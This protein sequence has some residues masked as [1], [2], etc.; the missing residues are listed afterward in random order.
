MFK[1]I[2]A[3]A[4]ILPLM[5]SSFSQAGVISYGQTLE[6]LC[7]D[8]TVSA[9]DYSIRNQ[10]EIPAYANPNNIQPAKEI[11]LFVP[12]EFKNAEMIVLN[13]AVNRVSKSTF[14]E[15]LLTKILRRDNGEDSSIVNVKLFFE[16][17]IEFGRANFNK[18][19][20]VTE[21]DSIHELYGA[22]D[23][24]GENGTI[25]LNNYQYNVNLPYTFIHELFHLLDGNEKIGDHIIDNFL[26]E[27]R[28]LLAEIKFHQEHIKYHEEKK[29]YYMAS[30]W[31]DQFFGY[32]TNT[33]KEAFKKTLD[34]L[35]PE[36]PQMSAID[37]NSFQFLVERLGYGNT[38]SPSIR[39]GFT[40]DPQILKSLAKTN[41]EKRDY[42]ENFFDKSENREHLNPSYLNNIRP[43]GLNNFESIGGPRP[44]GATGG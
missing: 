10:K 21:R 41:K 35:Y 22:F 6:A 26:A 8:C 36:N 32:F 7:L 44:R 28:A 1:K 11:V 27:Y 34:L 23:S 13:N 4:F 29:Q 2:L 31:H 18:P 40:N 3:I 43:Q 19:M 12:P 38:L 25:A 9:W 16:I 14:A 37:K 15:K 5:T 39:V 24:N 33:Q 20:W 17:P 30:K 42:I